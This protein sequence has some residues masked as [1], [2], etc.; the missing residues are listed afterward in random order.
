VLFCFSF[1]KQ[2]GREEMYVDGRERGGELGN[3]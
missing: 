3:I 2:I 1:E